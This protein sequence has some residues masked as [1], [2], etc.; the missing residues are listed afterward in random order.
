[1][2]N[3]KHIFIHP[4]HIENLDEKYSR[5]EKNKKDPIKTGYT[6]ICL[7]RNSRKHRDILLKSN[8]VREKCKSGVF[9]LFKIVN[10]KEVMFQP[11]PVEFSNR[12]SICHIQRRFFPFFKKYAYRS[13]L[14][15]APEPSMILMHSDVDPL[16]SEYTF[17]LEEYKI[18]DEVFGEVF[19][20]KLNPLKMG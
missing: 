4:D 1:M 15:R 14:I 11:V 18:Q 2:T 12:T 20:Y 7:L 5:M 13:E 3:K 6:S 10:K 9:I 8:F 17:E 16:I 19:A